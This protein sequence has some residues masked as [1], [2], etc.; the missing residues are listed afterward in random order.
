MTNPSMEARCDEWLDIF[1]DMSQDPIGV[2][3]TTKE[4]IPTI[5]GDLQ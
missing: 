3:C 4:F 1:E 2:F 5:D